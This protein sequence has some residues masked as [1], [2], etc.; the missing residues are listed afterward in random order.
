MFVEK[1]NVSLNSSVNSTTELLRY[2]LLLARASLMAKMVQVVTKVSK[3]NDAHFTGRP[4]I[5][6]SSGKTETNFYQFF[7]D[8]MPY[9]KGF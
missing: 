3:T 1:L 2:S 4:K 8:L 6:S 9:E 7:S 5:L